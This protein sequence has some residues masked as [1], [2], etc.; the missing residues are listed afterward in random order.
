[1]PP[2]TSTFLPRLLSFSPLDA[3]S[4][5]LARREIPKLGGSTTGF[6]V[7]VVCLAVTIVVSCI[8]VYFL[9][10]DANRQR[11]RYQHQSAPA[12]SFTY[13]PSSAIHQRDAGR[14]GLGWIFVSESRNK[15]PS[16]NGAEGWI[17]TGSRDNWDSDSGDEGA[18][19]LG[20]RSDVALGQRLR[21]P[22]NVMSPDLLLRATSPSSSLSRHASDSNVRFEL[23]SG[24]LHREPHAPSPRPGLSNISTHFSPSSVPVSPL[25]TVAPRTTSPEPLSRASADFTIDHEGRKWSGNS[26]H[27]MRTV[28]GGTKFIESI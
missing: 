2:T 10:R 3:Q 17:R 1:M 12:S 23:V 8:A 22:P 15:E 24:S 18:R 16:R 27:N 4:G 19:A 9:L 7:L 28:E 26:D 21:T 6:I 5:A 11:G 14:T 25:S 20:S 13:S